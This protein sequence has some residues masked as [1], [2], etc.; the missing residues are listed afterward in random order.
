M[1]YN[2]I[3]IEILTSY[4]ISE[5]VIQFIRHN[6]NITFK[7]TD[8]VSNK[9]YLLRIH[10]PSTEGLF[11][12]Q[13]TLEGIKSEIKIL[14]ELNF[15][16]ILSAQKPVFNNLGMYITECKLDNFNQPCYAT[17]LEWIEGCT[18]TLKEDNIKEL[19]FT[20]G[21][22]LALFHKSFKDFKPTKDFIRPIYDLDRIDTA[23]D[24]LKYCV[25]VN[26]FSMDH[27]NIIKSVL[28][29]VKNQMKE[30]S[31]R[32]ETFGIIHA[33]LQPGNIVVNS[34]NPLLIDLGFC[35]FGYYLFDLGSAATVFP[36][37][38]RDTFLKGYSTKASFSF[39]DLKYIEGQIFMDTFISYV[40]FMRDNERNSWIKSSALKICDT[41]C[42]EFLE[43]KEV[44]YL[45]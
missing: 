22:N 20:F 10:K 45:L 37:E 15:K 11:G 28:I 42:K 17:I 13:H 33:D 25:E 12:L 21:Q 8:G 9:N 36:S 44:F 24:E 26:L 32:E 3:A 16:G 4:S 7:I 2:I 31:L 27:Y 23:I 30:L 35:G 41:L 14:Q 5:P 6:E 39:D 1:D 40:L 19:T 43:G 38:L 29:L 34:N 18:L